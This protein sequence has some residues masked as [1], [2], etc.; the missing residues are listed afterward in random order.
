[1][2][3]KYI[4]KATYSTDNRLRDQIWS[5]SKMSTRIPINRSLD[6]RIILK[7]AIWLLFIL[8]KSKPVPNKSTAVDI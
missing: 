1:M 5:I 4:S 6:F 8:N 3:L 2:S 7:V